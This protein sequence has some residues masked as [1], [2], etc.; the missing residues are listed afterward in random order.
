[1]FLEVLNT[2]NN[3]LISILRATVPVEPVSSGKARIHEVRV[4][5]IPYTISHD[6]SYRDGLVTAHVLANYVNHINKIEVEE[7]CD[8]W[9]L[10][11][12][13]GDKEDV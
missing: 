10:R 9:L 7:T 3:N 12:L 2:L 6:A 1:M 5:K 4:K 8:S 13:E 11:L